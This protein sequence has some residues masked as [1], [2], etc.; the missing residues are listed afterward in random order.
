MITTQGEV[1][2]HDLTQLLDLASAYVGAS[3]GEACSRLAAR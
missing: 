3:V 1:P 2:V